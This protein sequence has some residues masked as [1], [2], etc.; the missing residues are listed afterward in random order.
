MTKVN[1]KAIPE[2]RPGG[3]LEIRRTWKPGDTVTLEMK[4]PV[5]LV[6]SDPRVRENLGSVAVQR[7]PVVYC[8]ESVDN[9]GIEL[10]DLELPASPAFQAEWSPKLLG[11]VVALKGKGLVPSVAEDRRPL[12]RRLGSYKAAPARQLEVTAIPYYAWAYRGVSR[13]T[14]WLPRR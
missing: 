11:G 3:Y 4:M 13:M 10:R 14:V 1:G 8:V 2:G 9:P 5:E 7:G 12:Y 6:E